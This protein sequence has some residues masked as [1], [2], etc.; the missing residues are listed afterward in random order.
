VSPSPLPEGVFPDFS[1]V[2]V[3][4]RNYVNPR[5]YTFNVGYEQ[6][7]VPE[8]SVYVDYTYA[9]GRHLTRFLNYNVSDPVCCDSGPG[10]GNKFA[11]NGSPSGRSWVR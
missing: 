6:E 11:Y 10:T 7:V 9:E 5:S 4:D 3:F 1:G 8:V 2:R